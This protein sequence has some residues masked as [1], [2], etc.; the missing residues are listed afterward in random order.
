MSEKEIIE[1][2][3]NT[4]LD[5]LEYKKDM[6]AIE[7]LLDLYNK[8]KE[9]N[10]ELD[11]F[12]KEVLKKNLELVDG[13]YNDIIKDNYIHKDTIR[14]KIKELE[15]YGEILL[16]KESAISQFKANA[17]SIGYL[18]ELLEGDE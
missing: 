7:G 1:W 8:E 15:N 3:K 17:V 5:T 16:N 9:K 2:L 18:E 11:R 4:S 10:E 14:K 12:S 13:Q 6:E